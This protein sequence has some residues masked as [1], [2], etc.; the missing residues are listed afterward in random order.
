[1]KLTA[2]QIDEIWVEHGLD[3]CDAH[4]FAR[5]IEA[6]VLRLNGIGDAVTGSFMTREAAIEF[7]KLRH[8]GMTPTEQVIEAT[9]DAYSALFG[10]L[11]P[12]TPQ[13]QQAATVP[14]GCD[15]CLGGKVDAGGTMHDCDFPNCVA[16]KHEMQMKRDKVIL[17]L[18]ECIKTK[19]LAYRVSWSK[20]AA[21][22]MQKAAS[23]LSAAP[24]QG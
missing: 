10:D 24:K 20:N 12:V 14:D 11:S 15:H 21:I 2:E 4:G 13:P 8:P 3:E 5:A 1:M 19:H 9:I 18:N 6:E 17:E 23:M 16:A 22:V 7:W